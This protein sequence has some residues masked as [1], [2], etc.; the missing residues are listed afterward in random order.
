MDIAT[1]EHRNKL[2]NISPYGGIELENQ[3]CFPYKLPATE[4]HYVNKDY[5]ISDNIGGWPF[6]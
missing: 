1:N 3:I 2:H 4:S 5:I 6:I